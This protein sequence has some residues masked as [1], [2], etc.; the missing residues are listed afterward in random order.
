MFPDPAT[1][2][3]VSTPPRPREVCSHCALPCPPAESFCCPGCRAAHELITTC[4]LG[5]YYRLR[6]GDTAPPT[7]RP[8]DGEDLALSAQV[9]PDGLHQATVHITGLHCAACVWI[10]ERLPHLDPGVRQAQIWFGDESLR[11]V[12]DATRTDL[13]AIARLTARL[14]YR[15]RPQAGAPVA[16]RAARRQAAL[17]LA[18]A[19]ASAVGAM[20]LSLNLYAGDVTADLDAPSRQ[21]FGWLAFVV[22]LPAAT[23]CAMP[24]HR[25][26]LAQWRVGRRFGIDAA[27]SLVVVLGTVAS[28]GALLRGGGDLYVDAVSMFVAVLLA[29][30]HLAQSIR[31]RVLVS[32]EHLGDLLPRLARRVDGSRVEASALVADEMVLVR[33]GEI[34]PADGVVREQGEV[35]TALLTGESR[36]QTVV[37]GMAVFA[38]TTN[39]GGP[40]TL[41]V[42]KAGAATRLGQLLGEIAAASSAAPEESRLMRWFGPMV[43]LAAVAIGGAWALTDV[44]V[45]LRQAVAVVM[46]SCPCALGL[47]GP[48]VH[49]LATARAARRGILIRDA[50]AL[51]RMAGLRHAVFDKT[52][53]L[54]TGR[55]SV[56]TW[57]GR[58]DAAFLGAVLALEAQAHHPAGAAIAAWC[59]AHGAEPAIISDHREDPGLGVAGTWE[60]RRVQVGSPRCAGLA[61]TGASS[62]VVTIDGAI[63][64]RITLADTLRPEA[65]RMLAAARQRGLNVHL[66]SGDDATVTAAVGAQLGIAL[67]Q[68][69]GGCSPED[70]AAY[71]AALDGPALVVGDGFNDAPALARASVAVAVRGGLA[72]AVERC[73]IIITGGDG[74]LGLAL[75][76]VLAGAAAQAATSRWLIGLAVG[77]NLLGVGLVAAG[78]I[79]PWICA[80][81]MPLSSLVVVAVAGMGK[82]F[83][84]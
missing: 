23:W 46:V 74:H 65:G 83:S 80:I 61:A 52:G 25:G 32:G 63:S 48:L 76:R 70:K 26:A 19:A 5:D 17:R 10:L 42:T 21:I 28:L 34:L 59:A 78:L 9:R 4:G 22:A 11:V 14:G 58:D 67:T 39:V 73:H 53:T 27:A 38:G 37:P 36:A 43:I 81:L 54:T 71:V 49:A 30:R 57:E 15:L 44:G 6:E 18:V 1:A 69:R 29:G 2:V 45:G 31:D 56:V 41:S 40:L 64:A 24:F 35:D 20:H 12:F 60:G 84:R 62:A 66:L 3:S 47:A 16:R 55:P 50:L 8:D 77:Y 79:G 68:T 13:P 51:D 33:P 72:A 7:P 82:S 75:E